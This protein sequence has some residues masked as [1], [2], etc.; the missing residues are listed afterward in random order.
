MLTGLTDSWSPIHCV[1]EKCTNFKTAKL[2]IVRI[3]FDD[4]RQ[5]YSKVC[6]ID[7]ACFS[8]HVGLLFINRTPKTTRILT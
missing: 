7:F 2:E 3:D 8:F 4:I 1:S 6:R 5:K